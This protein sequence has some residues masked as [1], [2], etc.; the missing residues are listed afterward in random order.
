MLTGFKKW[1]ITFAR[2]RKRERG[3]TSQKTMS[4]GLEDCQLIWAENK[5]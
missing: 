2:E 1:K 5:L 4:L 3:I